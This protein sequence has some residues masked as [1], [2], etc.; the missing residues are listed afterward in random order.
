MLNFHN[1]KG[2]EVLDWVSPEQ[3][4]W[5]LL[6][7]DRGHSSDPEGTSGGREE[8]EGRDL[9]EEMTYRGVRTGEECSQKKKH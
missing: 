8:P 7:S 5:W 6:V 4:R 3:E 9:S 1:S 2:W